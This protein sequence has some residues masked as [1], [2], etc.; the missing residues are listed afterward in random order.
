[1]NISKDMPMVTYQRFAKDKIA[2]GIKFSFWTWFYS[3]CTL[4]NSDLLPYWEKGCLMGFL[5]RE[6]IA[7]KLGSMNMPA[8]LLR[9]SDSQLGTVSVSS[10]KHDGT[11]AM[12]HLPFL[13]ESEKLEKAGSLIEL[14]RDF[15]QL[16]AVRHFCDKD[17]VMKDKG[18]FFEDPDLQTKKKEADAGPTATGYHKIKMVMKGGDDDEDDASDRTPSTLASPEVFYPSRSPTRSPS[19][20]ML[21]SPYADAAA[22][23]SPYFVGEQQNSPY[24]PYNMSSPQNISGNPSS[25]ARNNSSGITSSPV[26]GGYLSNSAPFLQGNGFPQSSQNYGGQTSFQNSMSCADEDVLDFFPNIQLNNMNGPSFYVE[27]LGQE[28]ATGD[29]FSSAYASS[30]TR[31]LSHMEVSDV[32]SDLNEAKKLKRS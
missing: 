21:I 8:F 11:G 30:I 24:S 13:L 31:N 7:Q 25:P 10:F 20:S 27:T 29:D 9:F 32:D 28:S 19:D 12:K 3:I 6:E 17:Y 26:N 16:R 14:L 18:F 2:S 22:V 15:D 23:Q 5:S 4:I 1:M